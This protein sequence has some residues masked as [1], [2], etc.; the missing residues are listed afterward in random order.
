MSESPPSCS[1]RGTGSSGGSG[2]RGRR[3]AVSAALS[4]QVENQGL[5]SLPV[6]VTIRVPV[7]L[8]DRDI[9]TDSSVLK[10]ANC[11]EN[12]KRPTVSDF[13][14]QLKTRPLVDCSVAECKELTCSVPLLESRQK[15]LYNLSGTVSSAWIELTQLQSVNLVTLASLQFDTKRF[16][17][18]F[19]TTQEDYIKTQV[20]TRIE[21]YTEY[22]YKREIIGGAAGG[23]LLLALIT[24]GLYKAGFFKRGYKQMMEQEAGEKGAGEEAE[25][26]EEAP[27][28]AE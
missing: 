14:K 23:L 26:G 25:A 28:A 9:W 4:L 27:P 12:S 8:G 16:I 11:T 17:H 24:A 6:T 1:P 5:R 19:T 22:D 3:A 10:I 2:T 18:V 20:E 15:L 7:R 13:V 21:L